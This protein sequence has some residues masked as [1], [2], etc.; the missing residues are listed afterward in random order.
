MS[1][2][3]KYTKIT[4]HDKTVH[5]APVTAK[6]KLLEQNNLQK[7][8]RKMKIE[9]V[10]LTD[11]ELA[12]HPATD[13][14][15]VPAAENNQLAMLKKLAASKDEENQELKN[16]LEELESK[17]GKVIVPPNLKAAELVTLINNAESAQE[18]DEL[19]GDDT[20]VSIT[21]AAAKRKSELSNL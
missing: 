14:T 1:E 5:F 19:V 9:D 18:V 6:R 7:A 21:S 17:Q 11:E 13:E 10:M 20:R 16:R 3:K 15:F 2:K 12:N 4:R 8:G